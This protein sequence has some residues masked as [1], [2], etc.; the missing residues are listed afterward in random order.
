MP[1]VVLYVHP[2]TPVF[3]VY[4]LDILINC[5]LVFRGCDRLM[6]RAKDYRNKVNVKTSDFKY[7]Y[8][9]DPIVH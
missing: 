6:N 7:V 4:S 5:H 8:K 3:A 9:I 2:L 1:G